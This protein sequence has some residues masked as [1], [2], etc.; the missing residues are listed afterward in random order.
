MQN[1]DNMLTTATET[2]LTNHDA[3]NPITRYGLF[4]AT[5]G[6]VSAASATGSLA[7]LGVLC[8]T[9]AGAAIA[10]SFFAGCVFGACSARNQNT[11]RGQSTCTP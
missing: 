5:G 1:N 8:S 11:E 6:I 2:Q 10:L 9:K 4:A 7:I 3:N